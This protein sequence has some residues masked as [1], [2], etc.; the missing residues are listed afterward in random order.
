MSKLI[1][2][3]TDCSPEAESALAWAASVARRDGGHVD[4]VHAAPIPREDRRLLE[5][6]REYYNRRIAEGMIPQNR[7]GVPKDIGLA[8]RAIAEGRLDYS[9]GAVLDISG[10]FQLHKQ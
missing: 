10:G 8:V 4:L 6:A 1:V 9:T 7:W 2:C 3:A 5:P